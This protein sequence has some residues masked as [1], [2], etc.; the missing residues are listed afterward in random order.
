MLRGEPVDVTTDVYSIGA[1]LYVLL[2]GRLPL[3]YEGLSITEIYEHAATAIPN[4]VSRF[5]PGLKADLDAIVAK[6]LAK[7]PEERYESVESL[8][9]DIRNYLNGLPVT[10][11]APSSFYR[12]RKF[13]NRHR[14][15]TAFFAFAVI[16]LSTIAGLA[17]RS[18]IISDRQAQQ[19]ALE[20]DRAE[21]TKEFLISIFDSA[22]PNVV[23]G[24]QTAREILE[25]SRERIE[26]ELTGQPAVQADLLK[27]MSDV[28]R[29]WRLTVEGQ[30]ILELEQEL[31]KEVNGE[32]SPEY[33]DVLLRL[34]V[35]TDIGGD[36]DSSLEYAERALQISKESNDATTEAYSHERIGRI[37]HLKGDF[38]G[39]GSHYR[40]ALELLDNDPGNEPIQV[41]YLREHLGNLL[42]HQQQYEAS[43]IEFRKS[44]EIRRRYISGDSS[45]ISPIYLGMGSALSKLDRLDE[46]FEAYQ[47]GYE[48]NERLYG[49]DNSYN[50]YFVNG[51]GKVAETR[52]DLESAES[53]YRE[54][55][56]LIVRHTPESPNLAFATANV[57]KINTLQGRYDLAIP[58][59]RKAAGILEQSLPTHWAL[60]D[61]KWRLG[62]CLVETGDYAEAE[63]LILSGIDI[64]ANQWGGD[65]E[66]TANARSA[67]ALLY[68][69]WGKP[70]KAQ[71]FR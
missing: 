13:I 69:S 57:A 5:N 1:L 61:V 55:M 44:L 54:A 52:G 60:G 37:L 40:R 32:T 53:H 58:Y 56:H 68:E 34:A 25:A 9:N 19:I 43:L 8:A 59:Y 39:A 18:A 38:D 26:H 71:A 28:Y 2:T 70:D 48:M 36:Y 64:V 46:A 66:I 29:S 15:G 41:A 62:R 30:E 35:N 42:V 24:D 45:E 67:A 27:A 12:V 17:V 33:A 6:A 21:Q 20:R 31:R 10:A 49:P 65:H 51:L 22:D 11:K 50:M 23:P 16:A 63:S 47:T 14:V 3:D 7:L 4:P